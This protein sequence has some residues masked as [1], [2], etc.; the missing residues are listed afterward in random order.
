MGIHTD[1]PVQTSLNYMK[2]RLVVKRFFR[3]SPNKTEKGGQDQ[4]ESP[5]REDRIKVDSVPTYNQTGK[6][7]RRPEQGQGPICRGRSRPDGNPRGG[8]SAV[9]LRAMEGQVADRRDGGSS[10]L[11]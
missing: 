10:K 9:A 3:V 4:L 2:I 11:D 1:K 8:R 5:E 7:L 6:R